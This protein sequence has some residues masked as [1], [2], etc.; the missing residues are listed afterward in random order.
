MPWYIYIIKVGYTISFNIYFTGCIILLS[1]FYLSQHCKVKS[2]SYQQDHKILIQSCWPGQVISVCWLVLNH[3]A[4]PSITVS[5]NFRCAP[6]FTEVKYWWHWQSERQCTWY[7]GSFCERGWRCP[8]IK[9]CR[10]HAQF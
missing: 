10:H 8:G 9:A 1:P 5:L 7:Q 3:N 2:F 4:L 6:V